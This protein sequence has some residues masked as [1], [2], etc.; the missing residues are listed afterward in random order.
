MTET[1]ATP[2]DP[3]PSD[4]KPFGP[5]SSDNET[6]KPMEPPHAAVPVMIAGLAESPLPPTEPPPAMIPPNPPAPDR[7][8]RPG[9]PIWATALVAVLLAG[10]LLYV[11]FDRSQDD[12]RVVSLESEL[13]NTQQRLV[14]LE[15]K[16]APDPAPLANRLGA[17][18][19]GL[20]ALQQRPS[21]TVDT[22]AIDQRLTALENRPAPDVAGPVAVA[23]APFT[24]RL[25]A[26]DAKLQQNAAQD[27]ARATAAA[28]LR[29]ASAALD[30]GQKLGDLPGAPEALSRY[31]Q[32]DPPTEA[33]L[34]LAF[35]AAAAAAEAASRP[36]R[37]GLNF[38]ERMLRRIQGLVTV[39]A[40][41]KVLVG[42]PASVILNAARGKLNAGDLAGA[43]ATLDTLDA[44]AAAAM[45]DWRVQTQDLL[46]ARS[47]LASLGAHS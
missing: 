31:A 2:S 30:A 19:T 14:S 28:R 38:G 11:Y 37:D 29:A 41:D 15:Q 9:T 32:V 18:E 7:P 47:A 22:S 5:K 8:A 13:H 16:P 24:G 33:G 44:P 36:A 42:P 20:K 1:N 6:V 39:R 3:T 26:L 12:A 43:L 35:P 45:A 23:V 4:P 34:R 25:D 17:V 27:A 21:Q 46:D 40:G 10:G